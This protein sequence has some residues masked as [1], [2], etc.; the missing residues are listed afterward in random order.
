MIPFYLWA[1]KHWSY[2]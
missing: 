2:T 1:N